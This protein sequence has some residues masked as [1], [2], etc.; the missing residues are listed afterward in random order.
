MCPSGGQGGG[1]WD[2]IRRSLRDTLSREFHPIVLLLPAA[3]TLL[4][5][6]YLFP[7]LSALVLCAGGYWAYHSSGRPGWR[8]PEWRQLIGGGAGRRLKPVPHRRHREPALKWTQSPLLLL[9]GS[10][11]GKQEPPVRAMGRGTRDLKERLSQPNPTVPTPARRLSFRETPGASNRTFMSPRR[12]YPTHQPQYSMPGALPM[13]YLDGYQ[14]KSLLSPK[15]YMVR[16]PVTVKIARPDPNITRSPVLDNLLS[17]CPASPPVLSAPDPCAKETVLNAIRESRKRINKDEEYNVVGDLENKRRRQASSGS[18]ESSFESPLANGVLSYVLRPD[19]LKRGLNTPL[20]DDNVIKRSRTSSNNSLNSSAMNGVI[21]MSAHNAITS[22]YSSSRDLLQKRKRSNQNTSAVSSS[23]SS[24]SQTPDLSAKKARDELHET[25]PLTPVGL[26]NREQSGQLNETHS[27]KSS[28][29][30]SSFENVSG[31]TRR[32]KVLLVCSGRAD[33]YPLPP[34]PLVGYNITSK[35]FDAEKKAFLQRLNKALEDPTDPVPVGSTSSTKA[36]SP[37]PSTIFSLPTTTPVTLGL[38]TSTAN[39]NPLLQSLAKMQS[40]EGSQAPAQTVSAETL[41]LNDKVPT[42][43]RSSLNEP[44]KINSLQPAPMAAGSLGSTTPQ[45]VDVAQPKSESPKNILHTLLTNP[46]ENDSQSRFK[47]IFPSNEGAN[48][49]TVSSSLMSTTSLPAANTF[50]PVFGDQNTQQGQPT[51]TFKPIFGDQNSQQGQPANTFKPIFGDPT[52]QQ[53]VSSASPFTFQMNTTSTASTPSFSGF[54]ATVTTNTTQ[55]TDGNTKPS[56]SLP[57]SNSSTTNFSLS[58]FPL[59]GTTNGVPAPASVNPFLGSNTTA[60]SQTKSTLMFG[61]K[62]TSQET[63]ILPVFGNAQTAPTSTSQPQ[64][65][66]MFA[67]TTSAFTAALGSHPPSFS[68][69]S[70]TSNFN[71][72][73]GS[74][75]QADKPTPTSVVGFGASGGQASFGAGSQP[76][77]GSNSQP[78]FGSNSQSAFGTNPNFTFGTTPAAS[79]AT[80]FGSMN[81][82]QTNSTPTNLFGASKPFTS[83]AV[84]F[85]ANTAPTP[86]MSFENTPGAQNRTGNPNQCTPLSFVTPGPTENKIPFATPS[87]GQSSSTGAVAF[88][89]STPAAFANPG[90]S[91]GQASPGFSIGLTSKHSGA[92]QR[93]TARR[94]HPRKK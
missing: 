38:Q 55:S 61:Q 26:G 71:S 74:G 12:R 76:N 44:C 75:V 7:V 37:L 8:F 69:N 24:R 56:L 68:V 82:T 14:R 91:F 28:A 88:G 51:G 84:S 94:Q 13:V 2:R 19:N 15:N 64:Q 52:A 22:S 89:P 49:P 45:P 46:L 16:S 23:P 21:T 41:H 30:N 67:S 73:S 92:R 11:L 80:P 60:D 85:G 29:V 32:K 5:V 40:K 3:L 17:P 4:V 10:Y 81:S 65:S 78:A 39:S 77:F 59:A 54:G 36:N 93:V 43:A 86:T 33:H 66:T 47:P 9:M 87:F 6:V 50:K 62:P 48:P 34:P 20:L 35:D 27:A 42:L 18:A 25:S 58:S 70:G 83:T 53:P 72:S 1:F 90:S 79:K 57:T 63:P 31:G